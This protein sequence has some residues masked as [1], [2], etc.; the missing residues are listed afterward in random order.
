MSE[1]EQNEFTAEISAE[2]D[3]A[4]EAAAEAAAVKIAAED[5]GKAD[6]RTEKLPVIAIVG[7]PNVGKSSLFNTI[8]GRRLSIV[9]E[10]SGVTRDRVTAPV[11]WGG[12]RFQLIDTGGLVAMRGEKRK[13]DVWDEHIASQVESAVAEADV[14]ICVGN[15]QEGVTVLDEEVAA[16]LRGYGRKTVYAVNK[17]DNPQLV[18]E[19]NEFSRLGFAP[20][21]PISCEHNYRISDVVEAAL[22][23]LPEPEAGRRA[24]AADREKA[25]TKPFSI[26]LVGR[27]NV[28]KSSLVNAMLGEERVIVSDVAGTTRDAVD[29]DFAIRYRGEMT[30]ATL[31]DTAGL[32]KRTKVDTVVEYFSAMR[33]ESAIKRADL[34]LFVVEAS[35]DG[36]TSQ[37]KKIAAAVAANCKAAVIVANK[38]DLALEESGRRELAEEIRRTLPGMSF[39]PVVFTC[40]L[41]RSGI[42]ELLDG[43]VEI[44]EQFDM[45]FS[46]SLVNKVLADAFLN[47]TPPVVG[48]A[49]LKL[50]YAAMTVK[51]PPTFLLFVNNVKYCAPNY[52]VYLKKVL[53]SAFDLTGFPIR[54][55]LRERPKKV[56]SIHTEGRSA[57]SRRKKKPAS[58][59]AGAKNKS[60]SAS[61]GGAG[62]KKASGRTKKR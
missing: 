59:P 22:A 49:P 20:M 60:G 2:A 32:R 14:L 53:R 11:V 9:H 17:A 5:A 57:P 62:R 30:P 41:K 35:K 44:R 15:A 16:R 23:L 28:G 47:V 25:G 51:L 34:V 38:V 42:K 37:D 39:A 8:V 4:A 55:D 40:A 27:P 24:D 52:L 6:F 7:R 18:M 33:S 43:I 3:A 36:V 54:I 26:A 45:T 48:H 13:M 58:P 56:A 31:V 21:I 10:M 29:I 19:S 1:I 46:T 61:K 50:Y 12:R